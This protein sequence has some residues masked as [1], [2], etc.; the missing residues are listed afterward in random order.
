V[1]DKTRGANK[2]KHWLGTQPERIY[3]NKRRRVVLKPQN[4]GWR[5]WRHTTPRYIKTRGGGITNPRRPDT[6]D[7]AQ[8]HVGREQKN[9]RNTERE[10]TQP[11]R[12]DAEGEHTHPYKER[13][14]RAERGE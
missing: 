11:L 5:G 6:Q 3:Y 4:Y 13:R 8:Q 1:F 7:G 9:R 2:H 12:P 14:V 10:E